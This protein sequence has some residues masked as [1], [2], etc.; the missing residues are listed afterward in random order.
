MIMQS[1]DVFYTQTPPTY[2]KWF[3]PPSVNQPMIDNP[4]HE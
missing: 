4:K 2:G 3:S 1:Y